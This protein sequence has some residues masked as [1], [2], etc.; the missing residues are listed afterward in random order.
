MIVGI[1]YCGIYLR[2]NQYF[3]TKPVLDE[4]IILI[5]RTTRINIV[6]V[7]SYLILTLNLNRK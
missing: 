3:G 4:H 7:F 6:C 5:L 2:I 1:S